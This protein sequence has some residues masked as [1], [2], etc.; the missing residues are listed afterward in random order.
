MRWPEVAGMLLN[1]QTMLVLVSS[2][3]VPNYVAQHAH[4]C[5]RAVTHPAICNEA[6]IEIEL[7]VQVWWPV[8]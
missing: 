8:A 6:P 1:M 4:V 7:R 3:T 2:Y 5:C